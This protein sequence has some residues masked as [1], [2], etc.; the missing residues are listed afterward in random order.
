MATNKKIPTLLIG[1]VFPTLLFVF[2]PMWTSLFESTKNLEYEPQYVIELSGR[3]AGLEKWSELEIKYDNVRLD[4]PHIVGIKLTNSGDVPIE[5]QDF[6]SQLNIVFDKDAKVLGHKFVKVKPEEIE[7]V[8]TSENHQI[9]INP[10]LLNSGDSFI[11]EVLLDGKSPDFT[12]SARISGIDGLAQKERSGKD[13]IYL[14]KVI[15]TGVS[16]SSHVTLIH[17]PTYALIT[18]AFVCFVA[19]SLLDQ[20]PKQYDHTSNFVAWVVCLFVGVASTILGIHS[21]EMPFNES[22]VFSFVVTILAWFTLQ[23]MSYLAIKV[24]RGTSSRNKTFKSDS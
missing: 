19:C 16:T 7:L 10:T 17:F 24:L 23:Y 18:I 20:I 12:V 14:H 5:R 15:S 6:D 3:I 13:G 4:N 22:K 21:M 9:S 2:S 1:V 8:S 11:L